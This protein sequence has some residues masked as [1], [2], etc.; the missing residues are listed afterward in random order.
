MVCDCVPLIFCHCHLGGY[1]ARCAVVAYGSTRLRYI[2][3]HVST[4]TQYVLRISSAF[5]TLHTLLTPREVYSVVLK[6]SFIIYYLFRFALVATTFDSTATEPEVT[7]V[8]YFSS[9]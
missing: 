9:L 5:L 1:S 3:Y 6:E 4:T 2:H 7:K 8:A